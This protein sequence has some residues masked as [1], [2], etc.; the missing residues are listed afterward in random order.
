[1][2]F[3]DLKEKNLVQRLKKIRNRRERWKIWQGVAF[4]NCEGI[5][6]YLCRIKGIEILGFESGDCKK[7]ALGD[8]DISLIIPG[9]LNHAGCPKEG[10]IIIYGTL[11]Q[12]VHM[13]LWQRDGTVISKWGDNGPLVKHNWN[14][15]IPEY[16]KY[17]FFSA[18]EY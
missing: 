5:V 7:Y 16:G 6:D 3:V 2:D 8:R 9:I 18:I 13:G 14:Q 10:D 4:L 15:V 17:A 12:P 1:M 11:C